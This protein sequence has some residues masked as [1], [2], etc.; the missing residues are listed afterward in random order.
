MRTLEQ[1]STLADPGARSSLCE[2]VAKL[3]PQSPRQWGKMT[4][5]EMICHLNDS[6]LVSIGEKYA[7][8]DTNFLKRTVV[9]W[10]ALHTPIEWPHGVAT[11]PELLQGQ[12]GTAPVEWSRDCDALVRGIPAFAA[13]E[14]FAAHPIFGEMRKDDWLI[15][16]YRH[17]DHHLRQFAV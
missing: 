8:P 4:A 7:S 6:F 11:R 14:K 3:T 17:I 9:K 15:W 10:V 5:H 16:A 1:M 13:R 12:G 2:R